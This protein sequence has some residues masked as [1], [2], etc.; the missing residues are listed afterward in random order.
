MRRQTGGARKS[1]LGSGYVDDITDA[2]TMMD[3]VSFNLMV[4]HAEADLETLMTVPEDTF[5]VYTALSGYYAYIGAKQRMEERG[6]MN[7]DKLLSP[8]FH[9]GATAAEKERAYREAL[10]RNFFEG[11]YDL[12]Q[13]YNGMQIFCPGDIVQGSVCNFA[14]TM[15]YT[16]WHKGLYDFPMS[17]EGAN[18][19][20]IK[21][22][23][24]STQVPLFFILTEMDKKPKYARAFT[25]AKPKAEYKDFLLELAA[26]KDVPAFWAHLK[27]GAKK[28]NLLENIPDFVTEVFENIS[29]FD[30]LLIKRGFI[31]PDNKL[32]TEGIHATPTAGITLAN[33]LYDMKLPAGK[34]Y[35]FI[36]FSGCRNPI[37]L[38]GKNAPNALVGFPTHRTLPRNVELPRKV[39]R[40]LSLAPKER[41]EICAFGEA[42]HFNL[43]KVKALLNQTPQRTAA[44]AAIIEFG[45]FIQ[46]TGVKYMHME[47]PM[48]ALLSVGILFNWADELLTKAKYKRFI[49]IG[50]IAN[51][52]DI[53]LKPSPFL[54]MPED[55]EM[56]KKHKASVQYSKELLSAYKEAFGQFV[57]DLRKNAGKFEASFKTAG[58]LLMAEAAA[59]HFTGLT[60]EERG[61]FAAAEEAWFGA[62]LKREREAE[63]QMLLEQEYRRRASRINHLT[64]DFE[65]M[66]KRGVAHMKDV[67]A[68]MER[69]QAEIPGIETIEEQLRLERRFLLEINSE[70]P[71]GAPGITILDVLENGPPYTARVTEV[72]ELRELFMGKA[73]V[74]SQ[75]EEILKRASEITQIQKAYQSVRTA[76]EKRVGELEI[77]VAE[78]ERAMRV[79]ENLGR[80][81]ATKLAARWRGFKTRKALRGTARRGPVTARNNAVPPF[82]GP[83]AGANMNAMVKS[84]AALKPAGAGARAKP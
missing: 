78:L 35:K 18:R 65:V 31:H 40:R 38:V 27:A 43:E 14:H 61:A 74:R 56:Y 34:K 70:R 46:A 33:I 79:H 30:K 3:K 25:E 58:E 26:I 22:G 77:E 13:M 32:I 1:L 28:Y 47:D 60:K 84:I 72:L 7:M 63:E 11:R 19:F 36:I 64:F 17:E 76:Y 73:E 49:P 59:P 50:S 39:A 4:C 29:A 6:T 83:N 9:H 8:E 82:W 62:L 20:L 45:T 42:R 81:L 2:D 53:L 69:F 16:L 10:F 67:A 41:G 21:P 48:F 55:S 24:P 80:R 15:R 66:A 44:Y 52:I 71:S 12:Y 51:T 5:L 68:A 23:A 37:S 57:Y 75:L 54:S